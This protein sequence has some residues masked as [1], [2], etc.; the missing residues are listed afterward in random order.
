[1]EHTADRTGATFLSQTRLQDPAPASQPDEQDGRVCGACEPSATL[2]HLPPVGEIGFD[3][4]SLI[5]IIE[6]RRTVREY[7]PDPLAKWELSLMLHY[8]QG[9]SEN[10]GGPHLRN[11][12]S[13]GA[14]H[15]FETYILVNRVDG[16][17][18]GI[19]RYLP[20]DQALV[21]EKCHLGDAR[22]IA[23]ACRRPD[24]VSG[25]AVTFIWVAIPDRVVWKFG[26]RGWRYLF[27][28]AGHV[29]QNLYLVATSLGCGACA[30]GSFRDDELNCA[31]AIDGEEQFCIYM[32]SVG[33]KK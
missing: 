10:S 28:E 11:V 15:P 2:V 7:S 29:C 16:L 24:L 27:I 9:V 30:I 13:A 18:P 17:E 21:R 20:L 5:D 4:D 14:L 8:T 33:R 32:A 12:P 19:Y 26:A 6:R 22:S 1:M 23:A 25:S 3:A 31:L